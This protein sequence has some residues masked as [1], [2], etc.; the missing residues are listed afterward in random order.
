MTTITGLEHALYSDR[1]TI[2]AWA[3][4]AGGPFARTLAIRRNW[5][6]ARRYSVDGGPEI[7][8]DALRRRIDRDF[9]SWALHAG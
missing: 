4:F 1:P 5:L 3:A 9:A 8:I 2:E 7:A 6:G